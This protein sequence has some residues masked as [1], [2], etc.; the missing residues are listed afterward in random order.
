M[1]I[2]FYRS[3]FRLLDQLTPD[4]L[5]VQNKFV[6]NATLLNQ[7]WCDLFKERNV[8]VDVSVDGPEWLH[9]ANRIDRLERGTF[10][11]V[12]NGIELLR[13]NNIRFVTISVI[14]AKSLNA[15]EELWQ[16]YRQ[17]GVKHVNFT[18]EEISG[19]H[20]CN[21]LDSN[22]DM[23]RLQ[24]FLGNLL[25]LRDQE[26]PGVYIREVDELINQLR[27]SKDTIK[28]PEIVP[29][30]IMNISWD[31]YISTFCP[32]LLGAKHPLYG[33]FVLGNVATHSLSDI[34]RSDKLKTMYED[35]SRGVSE[36]ER[37]CKYFRICGGGSPSAKLFEH[38]RFDTTETLACKFRVKA[39]GNAVFEYMK[40]LLVEAGA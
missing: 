3:A 16:F 1:P 31:G 32:Q 34:C 29:L 38:G 11:R 6:T 12:M 28:R 22:Q 33:D 19:V 37:S 4:G 39:V 18:I 36:C 20:T 25:A 24:T 2:A 17:I 7:A 5:L 10:H 27:T 14:S 21:S 8:Q 26:D 13:K 23:Q 15:A 30:K 9:D 35:I 40:Q